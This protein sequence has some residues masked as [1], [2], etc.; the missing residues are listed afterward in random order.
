MVSPERGPHPAMF[1]F[2]RIAQP[3][4][5][6]L[7]H[8]AGGNG[9]TH[10]FTLLLTNEMHFLD[11]AGL[12][13][14]SVVLRVGGYVSARFGFELEEGRRFGPQSTVEVRLPELNA[15]VVDSGGPGLW[16]AAEV[17]LDVDVR[18]RDAECPLPT[19]RIE[20]H[21]QFC[22]DGHLSPD[23]CRCTVP[24]YLDE[25]VKPAGDPGQS[26]PHRSEG[27]DGALEM[28]TDG[29]VL[30]MTSDGSLS[31]S[32][33]SDVKSAKKGAYVLGMRPNLFRAGTDNDG[34]K[35]LGDQ[36]DDE[37]KPL[38]RW[39][40]LGLDD[41]TLE[42]CEVSF[43]DRASVVTTA[44]MCGWPGRTR[45]GGIPL[46]RRLY[47]K[48][49]DGPATKVPLGTWRQTFTM[50]PNGSLSVRVSMDIDG[51]LRDLPRIGIEMSVPGDL[52]CLRCFADGS[53][54]RDEVWGCPTGENYADRRFAAHSGVFEF[55]ADSADEYVVPQAQG[56]RMNLRWLMLTESRQPCPTSDGVEDTS[57]SP[58]CI[59]TPGELIDRTVKGATGLFVVPLPSQM[60]D[61]D[62]TALSG[63]PQFSVSRLTETDVFRARH[64]HE[65]DPSGET[66]YVRLDAA[67]RGLGTG[68]CGPQTLERYRVHGGRAYDIEFLIKPLG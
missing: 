10:D 11:L 63:L 26:Y 33:R 4:G 17:H 38:G 15:F 61:G 66:V 40:S 42:D 46:A 67:Q 44:A 47:E 6:D 20:A 52:G 2:R 35:Q 27:E 55:E 62:G 31:L 59:P 43:P 48:L 29:H 12:V 64:V 18:G 58:A 32:S 36:F 16:S 23:R 45:H 14:G 54:E 5:I 24:A 53:G 25:A 37:S 68:S 49:G 30:R 34:V 50:H 13:E 19:P 7:R 39:L 22:L 1:E 3:V 65:L 8:S 41:V 9:Q 56:N 28:S 60:G 57:S 51:A 21:A